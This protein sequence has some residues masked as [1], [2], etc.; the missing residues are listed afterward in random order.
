MQHFK[1]ARSLGLS[2]LKTVLDGGGGCIL[3]RENDAQVSE[4]CNNGKVQILL[5]RLRN[6]EIAALLGGGRMS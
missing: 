1:K 2:N 6:P 3:V 4:M 5:T